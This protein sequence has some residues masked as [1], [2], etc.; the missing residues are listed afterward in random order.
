M[1][2]RSITVSGVRGFSK[3]QTIELAVPNGSPGSGL[4]VLVGPNG[5]GKSTIVEAFAHMSGTGT[6]TF[7]EDRRNDEAGG[8]VLISV[9]THQDKVFSL[10]TVAGGGSETEWTGESGSGRLSF[11]VVPSRRFFPPLF[12]RPSEFDRD[13]YSFGLQ[14]YDRGSPLHDFPRRLMALLRDPVLKANFDR[15]VS[16]VIDDAPE[17]TMDESMSGQH[18]VR[19][20]RGS[21]SHNSSGLGDGFLSVLFLIDALHDADRDTVTILDEPELS[22]HP[23][24]QRNISD[25]ILTEAAD[26]QLIVATHSP[27]FVRWEAIRAGGK[28]VR[29]HRSNG[30]STVSP[31]AAETG[32][33]LSKQIENRFNPHVLGLDTHR[34]VY[35]RYGAIFRYFDSLLVGLTATPREEVD[36]NTYRLFD[37]EPGV[38][39]DAYELAR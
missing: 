35:Q 33:Q 29:V 22:L 20:S 17:W 8:K 4:T 10:E 16:H 3:S 30:S 32:K 37:L 28:L 15:L 13:S 18:F 34:S 19:V 12:G 6:P 9:R 14:S 24:V 38:P 5:G 23:S 26:K 36:K 2:I 21:G 39:T 1:L 11:Y 7:S 27:Y 25:L 31:L